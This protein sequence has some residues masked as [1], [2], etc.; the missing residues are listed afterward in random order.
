[1]NIDGTCWIL[2]FLDEAASEIMSAEAGT[3]SPEQIEA[4]VAHEQAHL[5][6]KDVL[7]SAVVKWLKD[8]LPFFPASEELW[9]Y[10]VLMRELRADRWASQKVDPLVLAESL[11]EVAQHP[12]SVLINDCVALSGQDALHGLD[13]RVQ[14]LINPSIIP[15]KMA[16]HGLWLWI[17]LA[18]CPLL[19]IPFHH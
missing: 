16:W 12:S 11:L 2:L 1:M 4:M 8:L 9:K 7:S 15:Q 18:C 6:Y 17:L 13:L 3:F 10:V 14:A 5:I 19:I